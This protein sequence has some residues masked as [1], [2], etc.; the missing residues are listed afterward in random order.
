MK[1]EPSAAILIDCWDQPGGTLHTVQSAN[2][3]S[4][5]ENIDSIE[6][7]MLATYDALTEHTTS[8]TLWYTNFRKMFGEQPVDPDSKD[9]ETTEPSILNYNNPKKFQIALTEMWQL[10]KYLESNLH[11]T[12]LFVFGRAWEQCVKLRPLG[13]DN[14][15]KI[16]NVDVLTNAYCVSTMDG[17]NPDLGKDLSWQSLGKNIWKLKK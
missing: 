6:T 12:N 5:I 14:L 4:F 16:N 11:I 17:V 3:L 2:I 8:Q 9:D 7:V 13:Y 10:E 15:S 1:F